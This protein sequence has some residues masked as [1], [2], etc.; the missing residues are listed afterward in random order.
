[1]EIGGVTP[2]LQS[3]P[4]EGKQRVPRD[5]TPVMDGDTSH[6]SDQSHFKQS[7]SPDEMNRGLGVYPTTYN[8]R[9]RIV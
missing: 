4:Q 9:G 7:V 2:V 5:R 6:L 3:L 8:N 1:M